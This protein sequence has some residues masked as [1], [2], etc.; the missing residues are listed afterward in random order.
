MASSIRVEGIGKRVTPTFPPAVPPYLTAEALNQL[1]V[2]RQLFASRVE[3]FGY[4][5]AVEEFRDAEAR[6][7]AAT[8]SYLDVLDHQRIYGTVWLTD[9]LRH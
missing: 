3:H 6:A 2:V 9:V 1:D 7:I 8:N 4:A 5:H